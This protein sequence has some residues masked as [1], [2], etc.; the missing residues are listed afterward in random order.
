VIAADNVGVGAP[1]AFTV[2]SKW[3]RQSAVAINR[4]RADFTD[5]AMTLNNLKFLIQK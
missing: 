5:V 2:A 1:G 4:V 3:F